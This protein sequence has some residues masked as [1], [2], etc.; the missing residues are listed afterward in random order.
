MDCFHPRFHFAAVW[1]LTV[2]GVPLSMFSP[3]GGG[4]D[5]LGMRQIIHHFPREFDRTL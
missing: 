3:R 4:G 5:T 1:N 2:D